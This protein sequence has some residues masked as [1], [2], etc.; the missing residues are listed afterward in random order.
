ML[1]LLDSKRDVPFVVLHNAKKHSEIPHW[2]SKW[3]CFYVIYREIEKNA[4]PSFAL[5]VQFIF[6]EN[7]F[8]PFLAILQISSI[9]IEPTISNF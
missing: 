3:H 5:F 6:I 7:Y 8:L 2:K 9:F 4:L 1:A